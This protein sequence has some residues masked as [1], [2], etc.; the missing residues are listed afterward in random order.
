MMTLAD[1]LSVLVD[2]TIVAG[3]TCGVE[4]A[5]V[6]TIA[7]E[8]LETHGALTFC[9]SLSGLDPFNAYS[10]PVFV[11][12]HGLHVIANTVNDG[13]SSMGWRHSVDAVI[14]AL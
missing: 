1:M 2:T 7:V 10:N 11:G 4:S 14:A 3:T 5:A 8:I 6:G 9:E 12:N 13:Y